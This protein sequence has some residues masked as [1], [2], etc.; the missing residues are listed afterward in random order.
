MALLQPPLLQTQILSCRKRGQEP[1]GSP[2]R[3]HMLDKK[4]PH[5]DSYPGWW[6]VK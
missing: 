6:G 1:Q 5:L 3:P 4:K 2:Q